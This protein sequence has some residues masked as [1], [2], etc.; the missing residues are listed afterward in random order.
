M[1]FR[2][3]ENV[4]KIL[5]L[6]GGNLMNRMSLMMVI[7]LISC[8]MISCNSESAEVMQL[9]ETISNL[10][11]ELSVSSDNATEYKNKYDL[12]SERIESLEAINDQLNSEV[13]ELKSKLTLSNGY[14]GQ[15]MF[16]LDELYDLLN[17]PILL[18]E[19]QD[20]IDLMNRLTFKI[21]DSQEFANKKIIYLKNNLID[22]EGNY[23][24]EMLVFSPVSYDNLIE[25]IDLNDSPPFP[26]VR[27]YSLSVT[28]SND[29]L[30]Y[31]VN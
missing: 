8:V 22:A 23:I 2:H 17:C 6:V 19:N 28:L 20:I 13:G 21:N 18:D 5:K 30:T 3:L 24:F 1:D 12:Q 10:E 31:K 29:E 15:F 16:D 11:N 7:L 14:A 26:S 25:L 9:R 4:H 27:L